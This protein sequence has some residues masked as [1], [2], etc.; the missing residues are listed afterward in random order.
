MLAVA[1]TLAMAL[2]PSS[3]AHAEESQF[4]F[5]TIPRAEFDA[6]A[7]RGPV[8]TNWALAYQ[9]AEYRPDDYGYPLVVDGVV[10]VRARGAAAQQVALDMASGVSV[11]FEHGHGK[12][13]HMT[14]AVTDGPIRVEPSQ[15]VASHEQELAAK[16]ASLG[17]APEYRGTGLKGVSVSPWDGRYVVTVH[18]FSEAFATALRALVAPE[19][20]LIAIDDDPTTTSIASV[21]PGNVK[22]V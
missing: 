12:R 8:P 4:G 14:F 13:S 10:V 15:R 17:L 3:L 7:L 2:A 1:L 22:Q 20:V 9:L 18:K 6:M 5:Y 19:L 16:I 11:E 21:L